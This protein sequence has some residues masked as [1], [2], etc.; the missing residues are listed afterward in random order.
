MRREGEER[1]HGWSLDVVEVLGSAA[2]SVP[3]FG[4]SGELTR[5]AWDPRYPGLDAS[6]LGKVKGKSPKDGG[7]D[8]GFDGMCWGN[9]C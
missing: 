2:D 1:D 6:Y 5:G 4:P 8:W 9:C 3:G 7:L